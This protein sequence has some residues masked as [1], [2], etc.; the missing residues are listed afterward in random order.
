MKKTT[1]SQVFISCHTAVFLGNGKNEKTHAFNI[2]MQKEKSTVQAVQ[3]ESY[4]LEANIFDF[5]I[6]QLSRDKEAY[7]ISQRTRA[8]FL[9][10]IFGVFLIFGGPSQGSS[11]GVATSLNVASTRTNTNYTLPSGGAALTT[12]S[13]GIL[14]TGRVGWYKLTA[15]NSTITIKEST[16]N[17]LNRTLSVWA[18]C[19]VG[20]QVAGPCS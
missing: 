4:F 5:F 18:A 14:T 6:G 17:S 3:H 10:L 16:T 15:T 20:S 13:C 2:K 8:I 1:L 19:S 12:L 9:T 7:E 11:C